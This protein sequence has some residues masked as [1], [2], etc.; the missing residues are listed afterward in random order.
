MPGSSRT[1]VPRITTTVAAADFYLP[2]YLGLGMNRSIRR[3]HE[4]ATA[5]GVRISIGSLTRYSKVGNWVER[6]R[7]FD[8]DMAQKAI[9]GV[10]IDQI[11]ENRARQVQLGRLLQEV[12]IAEIQKR[13]NVRDLAPDSLSSIARIAEAGFRIERVASGEASDIRTVMVDI[14]GV[15][16]EQVTH[17]WMSGMER[18]R[19]VYEQRGVTDEATH[20][21]AWN[22]AAEQFAPALDTLVRDHFTRLGILDVVIGEVPGETEPEDDDD[23]DD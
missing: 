11:M 18:A 13:R 15:L 20:A 17:V 12:S 2:I 21:L 3:V 1:S 8:E 6:A 23:D 10:Q 7:V 22:T 4:V 16:I 9:A 19:A 5:A 14:Y